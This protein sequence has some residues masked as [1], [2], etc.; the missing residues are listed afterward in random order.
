MKVT[1]PGP[2]PSCQTAIEYLYQ[3]E[4]I[5]YFSRILII[6]ACC[7]ECGYRYVDTQI[8]EQR[9]PARWELDVSCVDDLVIRVVRS[10]SGSICIPELGV[11]IDPGPA[12]EGFIS[13]VEGI[14]SRIEKVVD[15]ALL[16]A[17]PEEKANA[18]ILKD[19]MAAVRA[20]EF[21]ITLILEDRNGNSLIV[22][23]KA[24]KMAC[25]EETG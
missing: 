1:V 9:E 18:E 8:L 20:G 25:S 19:K 14:I 23:E 15:G 13:N 10:T 12:C 3:T 21:P 4:E 5:P 11:Q 16:C 2:C 22:S 17:E 7:E 24:R 6:S